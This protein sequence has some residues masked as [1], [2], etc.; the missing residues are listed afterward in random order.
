MATSGLKN[1]WITR[2]GKNDT[3]NNGKPEI[4]PVHVALGT[5]QLVQIAKIFL[6]G[7]HSLI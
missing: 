7:K 2:H 3:S 1:P 6:A 5:R 4:I